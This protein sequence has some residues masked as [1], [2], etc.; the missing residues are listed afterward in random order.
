MPSSSSAGKSTHEMAKKRRR[1]SLLF[2]IGAFVLIGILSLV[3][4]NAELFRLSSG[5]ILI[6]LVIILFVIPW[7]TKKTL[8]RQAKEERRAIRG[9][10]AEEKVASLLLGLETENFHVLHDIPSRY[11]NID[12]IVISKA[13]VFLVETKS[14]PG[15]V[16]L[17]TGRLL[18]NGKP[19]EKDFLAQALKNAYW[20][21]EMIQT[22]TGQRVWVTPIIVFTNA[23]VPFGKPIK[24]VEVINKR[25]LIERLRKTTGYQA[26]PVWDKRDEITHRLMTGKQ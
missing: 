18:I 25:Y 4:Q 9:A 15:K 23:F 8:Y 26:S 13:N 5:L 19:P 17:R 11:G 22:M 2:S 16:E 21:R 12:H 14:H 20:L 7:I 10:R 6:L 3:V 24:G 1:K